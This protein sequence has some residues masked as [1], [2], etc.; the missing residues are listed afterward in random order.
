[1][2]RD[3]VEAG[4]DESKWDQPY[5]RVSDETACRPRGMQS[6]GKTLAQYYCNMMLRPG[7]ETVLIISSWGTEERNDEA[8]LNYNER[9][10]KAL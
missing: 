8:I 1:M 6:L 7:S 5:Q 9:Q 3:E 10:R 4:S 2:A